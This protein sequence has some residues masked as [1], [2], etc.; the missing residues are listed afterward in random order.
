MLTTPNEDGGGSRYPTVT[1]FDDVCRKRMDSRG[2]KG[3]PEDELREV[4]R[5]ELR[6]L[7]NTEVK[8]DE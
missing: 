2:L 4:F 6:V 7:D 8:R 1:R 3:S 5:Q